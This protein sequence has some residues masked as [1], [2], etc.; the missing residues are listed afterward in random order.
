MW[1]LAIDPRVK[2]VAAY[3]GIG[4]NDY[5]RDKQVWL[6]SVPYIEPPK[7]PGE[8]IILASIAPESHVPFITAATLFLNGSNDHHGGHERGLESFKKFPKNVPWS[9]AIQARGHHC[10]TLNQQKQI[11]AQKMK[12]LTT[13]RNDYPSEIY[14]KVKSHFASL[15]NPWPDIRG[16]G[17]RSRKRSPMVNPE[18]FR[19]KKV[20]GHGIR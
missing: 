17:N 3:F 13:A 5:Y 1:N 8:E 7:S 16:S 19:L 15:H 6:Y 12:E 10:S 2:A 20:P 9:F 18:K 14:E 11:N 4:Y